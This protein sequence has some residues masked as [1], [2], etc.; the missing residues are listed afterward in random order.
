[1]TCLAVSQDVMAL[2]APIHVP[3]ALA[4]KAVRMIYQRAGV[5]VPSHREGA[6]GRHLYSLDARY[7]Q[8]GIEKLLQ[9]LESDAQHRAWPE[10]ISGFTI[11]HTAFFREPHHFEHL[12]TVLRQKGSCSIWSA[13]ASTGEEAYSIAMTINEVLGERASAPAAIL[14]T[15]ID[16]HAIAQAKEAVYDANRI[17]SLDEARIK[18]H[19]LKGT[20]QNNGQVKLK[21]SV[22]D[23]VRFD[24][25]NLND[26]SWPQL[27]PFDAVFCR[28]TMI[29]FDQETQK[30]LLKRFAGVI[31][32]GGFLYIGHSE[33]V[34]SLTDQFRLLGQTIYQRS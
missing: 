31:R 17:E 22:R 5:I 21:K 3:T 24:C 11:N 19:F 29:Y 12:A 28:N 1:M 6:I 34:T 26:R 10:F 7:G 2:V 20:G 8:A 14:A 4:Q 25:L 13:A 9:A 18:R 30:K 16:Q 15:D 27:G 32:P 23:R 33:S